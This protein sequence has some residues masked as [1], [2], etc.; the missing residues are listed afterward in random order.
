MHSGPG[1]KLNDK[2]I[3]LRPVTTDLAPI[4]SDIG[5]P[6]EGQIELEKIIY[7]ALIMRHAEGL[8][9][10]ARHQI[11]ATGSRAVATVVANKLRPLLKDKSIRFPKTSFDVAPT[12][13]RLPR[14][15]ATEPEPAADTAE[16]ELSSEDEEY[17]RKRLQGKRDDEPKKAS[18]RRRIRIRRKAK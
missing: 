6:M 14:Q 10:I 11:A 9:D 13:P 12:A 3:A 8:T 17:F 15:P 4:I 18:N 16:Y 1:K 7:N 2:M 5:K